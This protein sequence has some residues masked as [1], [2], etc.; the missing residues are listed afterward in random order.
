[1]AKKAD[2]LYP[3][4]SAASV[5]AKVTR[6]AAL[7]V[8]FSAYAGDETNGEIAW[9]S[10]YPSDARCVNWLKANMDPVFGWGNEC[11]FSWGTAK[12]MLEAK[13]APCRLDWPD[14]NE[15]SDNMKL[16][17][18]FLG[19]EDEQ[20]DELGSWFGKPVTEEVF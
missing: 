7:D 17:G 2:S 15:E 16:T 18:F 13:G 6:D 10:G 11:R 3:C 9:G 4:V 19:A 20:G 12:E 14:G 1:M 5:C 8:L